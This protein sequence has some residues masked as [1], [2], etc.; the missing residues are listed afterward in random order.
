[1]HMLYIHLYTPMLI[2]VP[3]TLYFYKP[4]R[5]LLIEL[6]INFLLP[7]ND[8]TH[9]R[10]WSP[11]Q[12]SY[13]QCCGAHLSR[14]IN[15]LSETTQMKATEK[16]IALLFVFMLLNIKLKKCVLSFGFVVADWDD[17]ETTKLSSNR[18]VTLFDIASLVTK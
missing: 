3:V 15:A 9:R 6:L 5:C 12:K 14:W 1:M 16:C 11:S 2:F 10:R 17:I 4:L 18:T 13:R 8:D 7:L